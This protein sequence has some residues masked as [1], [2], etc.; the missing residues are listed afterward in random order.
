M[1]LLPL[2][3]TTGLSGR[4]ASVP[5]RSSLI[6]RQ[7]KVSGCSLDFSCHT[8]TYLPVTD[9]TGSTRKSYSWD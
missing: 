2:N 6:S 4:L 1:T 9:G 3:Q 8:A 7:Q 5:E